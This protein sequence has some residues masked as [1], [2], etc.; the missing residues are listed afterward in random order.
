VG[1]VCLG[2]GVYGD[3]AAAFAGGVFEQAVGELQRGGAVGAHGLVEAVVEQDVGAAAA[4]EVASHAS[5]DEGYHA[6]GAE[7][8]PIEGHCVPLHGSEAEFGGDAQGCRAASA[9]RE[10][11]VADGSA[12]HV[13]ESLVAAA[14]FFADAAGG[15]D[16][17]PRVGHGVVGNEVA[18]GVDGTDDVWTQTNELAD[19]EEGGADVMLR[20]YVEELWRGSVVG[21]V[22]VGEGYFFGVVAGDEGVAEEL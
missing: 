7:G 17:E 12:E 14:E 9:V 5:C 6:L 19:H 20:E 13:F 15:L 2:P 11:D 8:L 21:A 22:V 18:G 16:G 3:G 10:A 1:G 4:A